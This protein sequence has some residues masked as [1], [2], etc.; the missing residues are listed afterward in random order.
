[1]RL[2]LGNAF[3]QRLVDTVEFIFVVALLDQQAFGQLQQ[4]LHLFTYAGPLTLDIPHHSAQYPLQFFGFF[5]SSFHLLGPC[6]S[7]L[8]VKVFLRYPIITLAQSDP[9]LFGL[10]D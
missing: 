9:F 8:A 3:Y 2:A 10:L 1:M 5:T 4:P 6:V 7:T